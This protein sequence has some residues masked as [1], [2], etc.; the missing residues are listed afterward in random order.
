MQLPQVQI[1]G[2]TLRSLLLRLWIFLLELPHE[3]MYEHAY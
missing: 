3:G 2:Q 1:M